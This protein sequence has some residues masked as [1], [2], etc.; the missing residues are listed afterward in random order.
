VQSKKFNISLCSLRRA[1]VLHQV[2]FLHLRGTVFWHDGA[3]APRDNFGF[4][5]GDFGLKI[6]V[7]QDFYLFSDSAS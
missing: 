5:I 4:W 6:Q 1:E 3:I 7:M 2:A